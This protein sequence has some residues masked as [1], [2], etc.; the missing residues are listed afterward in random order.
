[1]SHKASR[2]PLPPLRVGGQRA[3]AKD[4]TLRPV[5][6][7]ADRENV[8]GGET[9]QKRGRSL[10]GG[11]GGAGPG[12]TLTRPPPPPKRA[13]H[14]SFFQANLQHARGASGSLVKVMAE[15]SLP[16]VALVQEPWV[17]Q[18]AVRG[19]AGRDS[20]VHR[21]TSDLP[22]R[23]C[24]VAS[25]SLH[26]LPLPQ[27]SSRDIATAQLQMR[28]EGKEMTL[29][30]ASV[31]LP[32]DAGGLPPSQEMVK[33]VEYCLTRRLPLLLGCDANAHHEAW[34]EQYNDPRGTAL[35]DF[36]ASSGLELL[37]LKHVNGY[38]PQKLI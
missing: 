20:V 10:T 7:Q 36:I 35:M 2:L 5:S 17:V 30:I 28:L 33:V 37:S 6:R 27:F 25:K 23:A 24:I 16:A 9:I 31:Y 1:M 15:E 12:V 11:E 29:V 22:P 26:S 4:P 13:T 18:G 3:A 19:L 32:G 14:I 38:K 34:G 21:G 8:T